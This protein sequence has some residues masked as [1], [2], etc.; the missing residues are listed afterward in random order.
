MISH[1]ED[2]HIIAFAPPIDWRTRRH[3]GAIVSSP[4]YTT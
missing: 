1:V 4:A 2:V 3:R